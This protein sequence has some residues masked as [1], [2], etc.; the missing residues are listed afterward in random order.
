MIALAAP[1]VE[2][3]VAPIAECRDITPAAR[4]LQYPTERLIE[5]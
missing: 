5:V 2:F 3:D 1:Y 4:I